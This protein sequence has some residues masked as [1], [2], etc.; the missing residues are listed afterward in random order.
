[1]MMP[2]IGLIAG[3]GVDAAAWREHTSL[4]EAFDWRIITTGSEISPLDLSGLVWLWKPSQPA[5]QLAA[6]R[7]SLEQWVHSIL[8]H[9]VNN[10][11]P[12]VVAAVEPLNELDVDT[13]EQALAW[14]KTVQKML[15]KTYRKE[16]QGWVPAA[17]TDNSRIMLQADRPDSGHHLGETL[18]RLRTT[19]VLWQAR[20]RQQAERCLAVGVVLIALYVTLLLV[21]FPWKQ[22]EQART[23]PVA[24]QAWS[25]SDWQ[26]HLKDCKQLVESIQGRPFEKLT[27]AEQLRF[28][29]HLRWLPIALDWLQQKKSTREVIRLRA[30]V[31]ELLSTLEGLVDTWTSV[32]TTSLV[33]QTALQS[34]SRQLL[35][36]VFEPRP[37]PTILH[38]AAK[39]Y[40]LNERSTTVQLLKGV[41]AQKSS[42]AVRLAEIKTTLQKSIEQADSC[43]VHAP[44]L[45]TAWLQELNTSLDW[46]E[47]LLAKPAEAITL[48]E[49]RK[50][51]TPSLI[52]EAA[53]AE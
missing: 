37:P 10:L 48:E 17:L 26:Y 32:P 39:R 22:H 2:K 36:G 53:K 51:T 16:L 4:P 42:M 11:I 44:E 25:H 24:P 8:R 19:I 43:R 21:T 20:I 27:P 34:T 49:C 46:V 45:K 14:L 18:A 9:R 52:R 13:R 3:H 33:E 50:E 47:K 5:E 35:D 29:E 41:F 7:A 38:Q 1:M 40:W 23:L 15:R 6:E 31:S 28:T 30:Q 12:M